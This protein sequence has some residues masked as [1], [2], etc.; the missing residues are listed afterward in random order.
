V[1]R[2][3]KIMVFM[4]R[5]LKS[6]SLSILETSGPVQACNGVA[7]LFTFTQNNGNNSDFHPCMSVLVLALR[8]P[9][10]VFILEHV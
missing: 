7:L 6:E 5:L 10:T 1:P 2:A 8:L 4:C 9:A 3:D